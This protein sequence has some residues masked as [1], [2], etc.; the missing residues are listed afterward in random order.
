MLRDVKDGRGPPRSS[1]APDPLVGRPVDLAVA[2]GPRRGYL[3]PQ[4]PIVI[5]VVNTK[6]QVMT[7]MS[8]SEPQT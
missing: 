1:R 6:L 3:S 2:A 5:E 4:T 8:G 7:A